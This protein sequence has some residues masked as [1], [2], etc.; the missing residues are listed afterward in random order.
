VFLTQ[1]ET[2]NRDIGRTLDLGWQVLTKIPREDL[3]RIKQEYIEKYMN[4]AVS[5]P[6]TPPR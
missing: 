6:A 4:T 1:G 5:S 2:E 3:L